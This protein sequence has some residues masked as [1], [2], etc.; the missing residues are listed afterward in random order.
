M[1]EGSVHISIQILRR[2]HNDMKQIQ[3]ARRR[4]EG[5]DPKLS[6]IYTE[7][8]Q[9]YIKAKPQQRLLKGE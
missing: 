9:K 3:K 2:L 7:A 5:T 8:V 6:R 4:L 1:Q